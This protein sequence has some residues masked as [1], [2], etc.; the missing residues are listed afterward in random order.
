MTSFAPLRALCI[1]FSSFVTVTLLCLHYNVVSLP[2]VLNEL[3]L[4]KGIAED[5]L[6]YGALKYR[7]TV[8]HKSVRYR[9]K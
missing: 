5:S 8:L 1:K 3:R 7:N 9:A 2:I 6:R 4:C